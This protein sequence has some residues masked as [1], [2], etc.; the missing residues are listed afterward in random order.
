MAEILLVWLAISV[1]TSLLM[2][3]LLAE[4]APH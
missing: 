4:P 3:R 2:G 1:V